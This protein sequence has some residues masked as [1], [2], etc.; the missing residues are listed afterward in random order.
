MIRGVNANSF[1]TAAV[2]AAL[3]AKDEAFSVLDKAI[4]G[5]EPIVGLKEDPQLEKCIPIPRWKV[6]L[7]RMNFP[8]E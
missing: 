2:Y 8:P 7:R 1:R 3:G 5:R 4:E 6:R